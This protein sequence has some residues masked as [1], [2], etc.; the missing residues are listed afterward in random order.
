MTRK[1]LNEQMKES[2]AMIGGD[3]IAFLFMDDSGKIR[4]LEVSEVRPLNADQVGVFL[5]QAELFDE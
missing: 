4:Y 5:E 1:E 3:N 2:A